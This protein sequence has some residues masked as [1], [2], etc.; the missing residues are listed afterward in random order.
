MG[1]SRKRIP[2][3]L[4]VLLLFCL[5]ISAVPQEEQVVIPP[6]AHEKALQAVAALGPGR[7]ALE[8]TYKVVNIQGLASSVESKAE[9][10]KSA[11]QELGAKESDM[12]ILIELPGDILFDFD[13]WDIREDARETLTKVGLILSS[14]QRPVEITG[15]TDSKG[16]EDYNLQLSQKRADSVKQWLVRYS[17]MESSTITTQGKGEADPVAPN[18]L[19]DGSDNPD[20]RQKNRRVEIKI[21]K[22]QPP[23]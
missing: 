16:A 15:F 23:S 9:N 12:E 5:R 7:G 20:G 3:F 13:H 22:A 1:K 18:T 17:G 4:P 21:N 8:I 2:L 14:Y 19:P 10:L 6:D 11:L